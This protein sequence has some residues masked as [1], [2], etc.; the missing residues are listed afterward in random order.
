MRINIPI[1]VPVEDILG[2][3]R[4]GRKVKF[5]RKLKDKDDGSMSRLRNTLDDVKALLEFVDSKKPKDDKKKDDEP[6]KFSFG[7]AFTISWFVAFP[8]ALLQIWI[9]NHLGGWVQGLLPH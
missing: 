1:E 2:D 7:E 4:N 9:W 6:R 8:F 3:V 5:T